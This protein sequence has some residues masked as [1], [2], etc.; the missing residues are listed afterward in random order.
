MSLMWLRY[1]AAKRV[2]DAV[3]RVCDR[4]GKAVHRGDGA[5]THEGR[6][7]GVFDKILTRLFSDQALQEV[8]HILHSVLRLSRVVRGTL[9]FSEGAYVSADV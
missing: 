8:L 7:Q 1:R 3:E 2:A 4:A 6:D 9:C 5:E